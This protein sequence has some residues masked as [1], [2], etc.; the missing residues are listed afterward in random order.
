MLF[1]ML[2]KCYENVIQNSIFQ[3]LVTRIS[4]QCVVFCTVKQCVGFV[5]S[6]RLRTELTNYSFGLSYP[7]TAT[8]KFYFLIITF[9][10]WISF[11][12]GS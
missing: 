2:S 12:L 4:V 11:K 8:L 6:E 9:F 1:K 10:S 5:K 3:D 7:I